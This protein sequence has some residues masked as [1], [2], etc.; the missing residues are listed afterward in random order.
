[1]RY[2][3]AVCLNIGQRECTGIGPSTDH[4]TFALAQPASV[5]ARFGAHQCLSD[6]N[7]GDI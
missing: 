6:F 7:F 5:P 4:S 3:I 2:H 1:M